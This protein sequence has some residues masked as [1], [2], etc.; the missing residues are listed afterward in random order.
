M[1]TLTTPPPTHTPSR[2]QV[3]PHLRG[4][5]V[6]AGGEGEAHVAAPAPRRRPRRPHG[7]SVTQPFACFPTSLMCGTSHLPTYT[8]PA[9]PPTSP[10][11]PSTDTGRR[12]GAH[13]A[14]GRARAAAAAA[15]GGSGQG[16][17]ERLR[18]GV[19]LRRALRPAQDQALG[20]APWRRR[21]GGSG[22]G[23]Q[24]ASVDGNRG[25]W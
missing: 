11:S 16:G 12:A 6:P 22:G 23:S 2:K 15:G 24:R 17:R 5:R 20:P 3:R 18:G 10:P 1:Y 8:P 7:Q 25:R 9:N 14:A 19:P 13:H 21:A 4:R